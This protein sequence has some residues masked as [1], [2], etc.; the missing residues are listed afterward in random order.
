MCTRE[1]TCMVEAYIMKK[2]IAWS[3]MEFVKKMFR[4]HSLGFNSLQSF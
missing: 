2:G 4:F 1:D 3:N